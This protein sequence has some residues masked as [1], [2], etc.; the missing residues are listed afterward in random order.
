M[1]KMCP[2][3]TTIKTYTHKYLNIHALNIHAYILHGIKIHAHKSTGSVKHY[4]I[5]PDSS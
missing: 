2:A 5:W 3:M 1:Y 4:F